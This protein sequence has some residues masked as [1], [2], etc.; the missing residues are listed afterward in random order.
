MDLCTPWVRFQFPFP[1]QSN[2]QI[3][4][5]SRYHNV[6]LQVLHQ[7]EGRELILFKQFLQRFVADDHALVFR[8]LQVLFLTRQENEHVLLEIAPEELHKLS[9]QILG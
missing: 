5:L 6:L 3:A 1:T 4:I 8:V 9:N 7:R 2:K